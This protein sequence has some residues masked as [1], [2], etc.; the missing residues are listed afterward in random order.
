M[1]ATRNKRKELLKA[2][3]VKDNKKGRKGNPDVA[4]QPQSSAKQTLTT[5]KMKIRRQIYP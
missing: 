5:W 1:K 2:R 4:I 3:E